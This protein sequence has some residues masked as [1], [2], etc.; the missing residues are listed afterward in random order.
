MHLQLTICSFCLPLFTNVH[1]PCHSHLSR[2][3]SANSQMASYY[4]PSRRLSEWAAALLHP[5]L[6]LDSDSATTSSSLSVGLWS[7]DVRLRNVELRPEAF[8]RFLDPVGDDPRNDADDGAR[9][10]WKLVRGSVDGVEVRIPWKSLLVGSARAAAPAPGVARAGEGGRTTGS[11]DGGRG[12]EDGDGEDGDGD[13]GRGRTTVR[14]RGA[15]LLLGYDVVRPGTSS[16]AARPSGGPPGGAGR[17]GEGARERRERVL[18]DAE[19]RLLAGLE[20]FPPEAMAELQSALVSSMR[21]AVETSLPS[22]PSEPS[23]STTADEARTPPTDDG[24]GNSAANTKGTASIAKSYFNRVENYLSSTIKSLL[25]RVFDSL[26]LSVT[27]VQLSVVGPSHYDKDYASLLRR[28]HRTV[29]RTVVLA[30]LPRPPRPSP[31]PTRPRTHRRHRSA[32]SR[33]QRNLEAECVRRDSVDPVWAREGQVEIGVTLDRFDVRP[34]SLTPCGDA[35]SG[36][37]SAAA[38]R[39]SCVSK[40]V[41]VRGAGLFVQRRHLE[42]WRESLRENPAEADAGVHTGKTLVW[43]DIDGDDYVVAPTNMTA[44]ATVHRDT[45]MSVAVVKDADPSSTQDIEGGP[46]DVSVGTAITANNSMGT[47]GSK[48]RGKRDKRQP[49][50]EGASEAS[51][52]ADPRHLPTPLSPLTHPAPS[53]VSNVRRKGPASLLSASPTPLGSRA[54]L[55]FTTM[56]QSAG[57]DRRQHGTR[58]ADAAWPPRKLA[59]DLTVGHVRVSVSPRQLFLVN[60]FSSSLA[61]LQRGRPET[62]VRASRV[63]D[64]AVLARVAAEGKVVIVQDEH[65]YRELPAVLRSR[66]SSHSYRSLPGVVAA[67]WRY[68]MRNVLHEIQQQKSLLEQCRGSSGDGGGTTKTNVFS[69]TT[70]FKWHWPEHCRLRREYIDLYLLSQGSAAPASDTAVTAAKLRL[71]QL[72]DEMNVEQILLL[73]HVARADAVGRTIDDDRPVSPPVATRHRAPQHPLTSYGANESEIMSSCAVDDRTVGTASPL[74]QRD[75]KSIHPETSFSTSTQFG[76]TKSSYASGPSME[77][78][79]ELERESHATCETTCSNTP[80]ENTLVFSASV[81]LSG[82]SLALCEFD[83]GTSTQGNPDHGDTQCNLD[84]IS[85]LTPLSDDDDSTKQASGDAFDP[86][87]CF[88]PII[89]HGFHCKPIMLVHFADIAVS[90]QQSTNKNEHHAPHTKSQFSIGGI[91]C[92]GDLAD[93]QQYLL[94]GH[95]PAEATANSPVGAP[96]QTAS[97]GMMGQQISPNHATIGVAPV[98]ITVDWGWLEKSLQFFSQNKDA[99]PMRLTEPLQAEDLLVRA[100]SHH[101]HKT[102]ANFAS[103]TM[104]CDSLSLTIPVQRKTDHDMQEQNFIVTTFGHLHVNACNH[105]SGD[106]D[107]RTLADAHSNNLPPSQATV[108]IFMSKAGNGMCLH[109]PNN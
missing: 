53:P 58:S 44:Q 59:L 91:S 2:R 30:P 14:V 93:P 40:F 25:W 66:L 109:C 83:E 15:R 11:R 52:S 32:A 45:C 20:P 31:V 103:I 84:D 38:R 69:R 22:R 88:W 19:L 21:S 16:A 42:T 90:A 3:F 33:D 77:T 13:A 79:K 51:A 50:L 97:A 89:S 34:G 61:R 28:E 64:R 1:E 70:D 106:Q 105:C 10:R 80:K 85:A 23:S 74:R 17:P 99:R 71:E 41:R 68:A 101:Q 76:K 60:S 73:R 78:P 43:N 37:D 46:S 55:S 48:R 92:Q 108:R 56:E 67:W 107:N 72:E 100:F 98:E 47:S 49:T 27:Q 94:V 75:G 39:P 24:G 9:V 95:I 62:T 5:Y 96:R 82:I 87:C 63:R 18:R 36:S 6:D 81:F 104:E 57:A 86:S 12:G 29:E 4:S 26:S 65:I 102:S 7:G 8:A 35:G 54:T